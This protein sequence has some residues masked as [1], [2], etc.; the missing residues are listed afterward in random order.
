MADP[1]E[2][3]GSDETPQDAGIPEG[4]DQGEAKGT[5]NSDREK[6]EKAGRRDA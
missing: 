4:S 1:K 6:T 3:Q 2:T 5:P